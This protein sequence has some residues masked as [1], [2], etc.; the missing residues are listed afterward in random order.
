MDFGVE[1]EY[2]K[3]KSQ[4]GICEDVSSAVIVLL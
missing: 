3:E 1:Y 2:D 4:L